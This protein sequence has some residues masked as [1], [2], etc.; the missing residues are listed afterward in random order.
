[1]LNYAHTES[2]I[3]GVTKEISEDAFLKVAQASKIIDALW[4]VESVFSLLANS[5]IEFEECLLRLTL[6]YQYQHGMQRNADHFFDDAQQLVNLK[7]V[8]LLTA[9]R[10]Y[11]EQLMRR[12]SDLSKESGTEISIKDSFSSAFDGSL[13]YRVMYALRN[14]ALHNQLPLG[15]ISFSNALLFSSENNPDDPTRARITVNPKISVA[16]FCSSDRIKQS[17]RDEVS[18]LGLE[19]LD[20]KFFSRN[21]VACLAACHEEFRIRS[22]HAFENS[23][24]IMHTA[25]EELSKENGKQVEHSFVVKMNE[26]ETVEKYYVDYSNRSR[27]KELRKYWSGLRWAQNS[28]VSSEVVF[29]KNTFPTYDAK[30]WISK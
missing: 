12:A 8:S 10:V 20:L 14:H 23:L 19:F 28:F 25:Q 26:G 17:T 9:S 13:Q 18:N 15:T 16:E 30:L 21:F 29:A 6:N 27:L 3:G 2:Y 11:E 24:A 22:A 4:D 1:M 7:L 5:S